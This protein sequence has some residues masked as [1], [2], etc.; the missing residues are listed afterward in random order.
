M[1]WIEEQDWFGL[2]DMAEQAFQEEKNGSDFDID[3]M[4]WVTK[5][6]NYTK[7][8]DMS[9]PHILNSINRIQK[10]VLRGNPWRVE[11]LPVLKK[12]IQYRKYLTYLREID[13]KKFN[14]IVN[15]I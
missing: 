1:S 11:Y 4:I 9:T 5:D 10:S 15:K 6:G 14:K 2:E 13:N 7:I 12:E 8:S 3:S